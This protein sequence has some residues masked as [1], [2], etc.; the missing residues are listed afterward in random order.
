[1]TTW[2]INNAPMPLH[3]WRRLNW[4]LCISSIMMCALF[5]GVIP[6]VNRADAEATSRHLYQADDY[7]SAMG[8]EV[9]YL[10]RLK[11]EDGSRPL[12]KTSERLEVGT[13][14]FFL[15]DRSLKETKMGVFSRKTTTLLNLVFRGDH[16][17]PLHVS[18]PCSK[19]KFIV[20]DDAEASVAFAVDKTSFEASIEERARR[21]PETTDGSVGPIEYTPAWRQ[22]VQG[23]TR[24]GFTYD[25]RDNTIRSY[26]ASLTVVVS[27][28][29]M[30]QLEP[31]LR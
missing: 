8:V 9:G 19:V 18:V 24:R 10:Y 27:S 7:F 30:A 6:A 28:D 25:L 31:R 21:A 20:D 15:A 17:S 26:L 14:V 13:A 2:T 5:A 16:G 29:Q 12:L 1:M 11:I 23:K 4:A 22:V 3:I